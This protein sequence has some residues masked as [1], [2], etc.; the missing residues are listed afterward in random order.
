MTRPASPLPQPV[1]AD[2]DQPD[3]RSGYYYVSVTDAGRWGLLAGPYHNDHA[4][5]L[6]AVKATKQAAEQANSRAFWYAYGTVWSPTDL[7]PGLLN[8]HLPEP[9][10]PKGVG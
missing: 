2:R 9:L 5:A 8:T 4:A 1:P 10:R 6:A 7:G 3:D